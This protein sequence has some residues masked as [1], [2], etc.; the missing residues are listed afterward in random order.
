MTGWIALLLFLSSA[1]QAATTPDLLT[2]TN[3]NRQTPLW[4]SAAKAVTADGKLSPVYLDEYARRNLERRRTADKPSVHRDSASAEPRQC[5]G[6]RPAEIAASSRT[7]ADLSANAR[8]IVKG[9]I[10]QRAVGFFEDYPGTILTVRVDR[11]L[12]RD[13]TYP[14]LTEYLLYYP[15]ATFKVGETTYCIRPATHPARPKVGDRVLVY[16]YEPPADT[17][18]R[19]IYGQASKHL[20]FETAAGELIPPVDLREELASARITTLEQLFRRISRMNDGN[21]RSSERP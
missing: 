20:I 1:G 16:A 3:P 17:S 7:L 10:V 2:S 19:L 21:R 8:M 18:R 15:D 9:T 11:Q 5:S 13:T 4:V 6:E 14:S 12:H